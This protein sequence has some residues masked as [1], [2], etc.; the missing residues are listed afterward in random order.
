[1]T[2]RKK[3]KEIQEA[4]ELMR[5]ESR[6]KKAS[7]FIRNISIGSIIVFYFLSL[8]FYLMN[9]MDKSTEE[10]IAMALT[11]FSVIIM[12]IVVV[13]KI[14]TTRGNPLIITK[15]GIAF[16]HDIAEFWDDIQEYG[17]ESFKGWKK[18]YL[19]RKYGEGITLL[20]INKGL[21]QRNIL[22]NPSHSL[23]A[24]WAVFFTPEQIQEAEN[25]F[26]KYGIK[27]N[28]EWTYVEATNKD[29]KK[30]NSNY[31]LLLQIICIVIPT[32][33]LILLKILGILVVN[34]FYVLLI[35]LAVMDAVLIIL[36]IWQ[37]KKRQNKI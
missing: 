30:I 20:I 21:W 32:F 16:D 28:K 33:A 24:N 9:T 25:I 27:K 34:Y 29:G 7:A 22:P 2:K 31:V 11:A 8:Y 26:N 35:F 4:R 1:M 18:M 14:L 5:I 17:W 15:K 3:I 13:N 19:S 6:F 23:L 12:L 37:S 36:L 10:R